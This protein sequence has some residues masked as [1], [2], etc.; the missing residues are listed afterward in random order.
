MLKKSI[1]F[2]LLP[3]LCA[4]D[5]NTA[6]LDSYI[7]R[8][9]ASATVVAMANP[10]LPVFEV[11]PFSMESGRDPFATPLRETAKAQRN[12]DCWQPDLSRTIGVL[13]EYSLSNLKFKGVIGSKSY[14][15]A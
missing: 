3:A 8:T 1:Q 13:E 2:L 9:K 4:C 7:A 5:T 6:D 10:A 14:R 12:T 11:V 15:A